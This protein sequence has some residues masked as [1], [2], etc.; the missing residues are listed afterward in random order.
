MSLDESS[1]WCQNNDISSL[2][3]VTCSTFPG[4]GD[5]TPKLNR[6]YIGVFDICETALILPLLEAKV[7]SLYTKGF[8]N[9]IAGLYDRSPIAR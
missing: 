6:I 5:I 3:S 9:T 1:I 8:W 7:L 4:V 2:I